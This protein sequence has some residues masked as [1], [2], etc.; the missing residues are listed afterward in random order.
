MTVRENRGGQNDGFARFYFVKRAGAVVAYA[1]KQEAGG[2]EDADSLAGKA[3]GYFGNNTT[4]TF[5]GL[6]VTAVTSENEY[7][8]AGYYYRRET[9]R[10]TVIGATAPDYSA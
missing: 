7:D 10:A 8:V 2:V 3:I 9:L 1:Y 4:A 5:T 6:D